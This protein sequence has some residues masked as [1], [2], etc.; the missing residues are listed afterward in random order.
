MAVDVLNS[1]T[2]SAAL[3]ADNINFAVAS[4]TNISVGDVLV[5]RKEAMKVLAVDDPASGFVKV[6]RGFDGTR[7]F[8][9]PSGQRV[10]IGSPDKFKAMKEHAHAIVG[11]SGTFPDYLL[12]GQRAIDG[13]GN[14]YMLVELSQTSYGGTTVLISRDGLFTAIPLASGLAG[15][16]GLTVEAG[17]SDQLVWAQIYGLNSHAQL[18]GG[19]SLVTSTGVLQ[20]A[21]S[22]STPAVG[23]LGLTTSQASS[24]TN[25][26]IKG[27][28]PVSSASTAS[29]SATSATG[30]FCAVWLN[31]PFVQRVVTS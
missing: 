13:A 12:P 4:T 30:L 23:L 28:F 1:T 24:V 3:N 8:A 25:A 26:E 19:S 11:D 21:S 10:W 27:M 31:Y 7:A 2:L 14:E 17:T 5:V 29:T 9:Q 6:R 20:P 22:V 18:V 15:S 16:V